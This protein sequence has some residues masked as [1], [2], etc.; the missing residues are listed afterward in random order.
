MASTAEIRKTYTDFAKTLT[1]PKP[2]YAFAGV[3]DLAVEKVKSLRPTAE[4][5]GL[6]ERATK[7]PK[8]FAEKLVDLPKEAR[9]IGDKLTDRVDTQ[10]KAADERYEEL[11]KRGEDILKRVRTQKSTK[12][13]VDQAKTTISKARNVRGTATEGAKKTATA[14]KSTA[15][16]ARKTATKARSAAN[17]TADK[18]GD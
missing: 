13:L 5:A 12:D 8:Q 17:A 18:V 7:L 14:A 2:L 10:V 3:G 4:D 15:T 11:A 16:S 6:R 9:K 1:G